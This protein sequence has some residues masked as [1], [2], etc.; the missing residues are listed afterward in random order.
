[1]I[2]RRTLIAGGM[3]AGLSPW[4][5][6][7]HLSPSPAPRLERLAISPA[8]TTDLTI[9]RPS[10]AE[11]LRGVAL[12]ST[13]HGSWPERYAVLAGLLD[14]HGYA[15]LAPL[16]VDSVRHPDRAKF[17]MKDS[18]GERI[19]DMAATSA[20][21]AK[22]FPGLPVIAV[23]HSF[24]TLTAL[25]RAGGLSY[26]GDFRDPS[27]RAVLGF[28][29]PGR[30]PGLIQPNAYSS[31]AVPIML[32]TGTADFVPG[33]VT[34]PADH[35]LPVETAQAPA[36]GL[37]VAGA[38]HDFVGRNSP[39]V[40]GSSHLTR[41]FLNGYGGG[42]AAARARLANWKPETGDRFIVR[43]SA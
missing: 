17:T 18:F 15:T 4:P 37:V 33:F 24:G 12:L 42:D 16:H 23:G 39:G 9:W 2:S 22:A 8:R 35:L 21:A 31:V 1:M 10:G 38:D 34:D 25:C 43:N 27:V 29:S 14:E 7:A 13:G 3:V 5:L 41:D 19:A 26:A 40:W 6:R 28:S 32:I 30:I 36:F 11:R 20:Y